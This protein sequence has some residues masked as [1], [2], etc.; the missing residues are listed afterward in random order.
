MFAT[1]LNQCDETNPTRLITRI[2]GYKAFTVIP[3][4][5]RWGM[6]NEDWAGHQ[7]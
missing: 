5:I 4:A 1:I 6:E 7:R 2:M 3:P